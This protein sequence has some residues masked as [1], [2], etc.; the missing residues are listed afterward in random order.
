MVSPDGITSP[1]ARAS[2]SLLR[3]RARLRRGARTVRPA[4]AAAAKG[5]RMGASPSPPAVSRRRGS[6][7]RASA[8]GLAGRAG[9]GAEPRPV[10]SGRVGSIGSGRVRP[11]ASPPGAA[12]QPRAAAARSPGAAIATAGAATAACSRLPPD[13]CQVLQKSASG[14]SNLLLRGEL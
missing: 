14:E 7:R 8:G 9:L 3:P 1:G 10:G 4:G 2:G 13:D 11:A 12:P 5:H 6:C